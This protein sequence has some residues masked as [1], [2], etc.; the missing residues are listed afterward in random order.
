MSRSSSPIQFHFLT[1]CTLNQRTKLKRFVLG[2]FRKEKLALE[3]LTLVFCDDRSLLN[4]NIR[5]LKHD[6]Y[7]DILS[8]PLSGRG[9]PLVA[10]I[11]IS[12]E[13]VRENA[14][15]LDTSFKEELHRVIFHG[16]LHFCGYKDKT[17]AETRL[18]R[19]T[20]D[21]YLKSYS[22]PKKENKG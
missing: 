14:A 7:T 4:L 21:K 18:M 10:E 12:V 17:Q 9:K 16:I 1:P 11:Y 19:K 22:T 13:R 5:F 3:S 6:Y 15:N 20:E 2:I 8:F